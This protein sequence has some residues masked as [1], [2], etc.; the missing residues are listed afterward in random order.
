MGDEMLKISREEA[1]ELVELLSYAVSVGNDD[2]RVR[3]GRWL[4]VLHR[5]ASAADW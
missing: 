3:A 2:A 4:A 5:H 1:G